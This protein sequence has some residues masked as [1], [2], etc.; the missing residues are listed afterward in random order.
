MLQRRPGEAFQYV[1]TNGRDSRVDLR[2]HDGGQPRRVDVLAGQQQ[3]VDRYH[4]WGARA[5]QRR[6]RHDHERAAAGQS[7]RRRQHAGDPYPQRP[8]VRLAAERGRGEAEG[9]GRLRGGEH[10]L[11]APAAGRASSRAGTAGK[12]CVAATSAAYAAGSTASPVTSWPSGVVQPACST[13]RGMRDP[14]HGGQRS[15]RRGRQH[16]AGGLD[17]EWFAG[18]HDRDV[19]PGALPGRGDIASGDRVPEH[20][21]ERGHGEREDERERGQRR[22][23]RGP[24][25]PGQAHERGRAGPAAPSR[26]AARAARPGTPAAPRRPPGPR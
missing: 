2:V 6:Q 23:K 9:D 24:G 26:A 15:R 11:R 21:R 25:R 1:R 4:G 19:G 18:R 14:G 5:A 13:S 12:V 20:A 7:G 8:H 3:L 10:R 22:G 17:H 16:R